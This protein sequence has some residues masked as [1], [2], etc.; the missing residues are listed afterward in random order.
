MSLMTETKNEATSKTNSQKSQGIQGEAINDDE[1][2][3]EIILYRN[4]NAI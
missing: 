2:L 1:S 3:R 4:A